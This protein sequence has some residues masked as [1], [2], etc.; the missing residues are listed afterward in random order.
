[1]RQKKL[2]H[3]RTLPYQKSRSVAK[4]QQLN[5][6]ISAT[7]DQNFMILGSLDSSLPGASNRS[8]FMSFGLTDEMLFAK[9]F[10]Q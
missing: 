1:M 9:V 7:S 6:I 3:L 10:K 8:I 2:S 4:T 5:C